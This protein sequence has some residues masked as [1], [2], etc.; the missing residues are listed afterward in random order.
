MR[1]RLTTAL[2][3]ALIALGA[4][5]LLTRGPLV[6]QQAPATVIPTATVSAPAQSPSPPPSA[7]ESAR[8]TPGPRAIPD[9]YRVQVP[10]L[11]IDLAIK[12]GNLVCRLL[13]EKQKAD[14]IAVA[15]SITMSMY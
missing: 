3:L 15:K 1:P 7:S 13:L 9:G 2:A 4:W 6:S 10:R 12:E 8:A 11:R 5:I 14:G